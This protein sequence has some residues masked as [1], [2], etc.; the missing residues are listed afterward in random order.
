MS[1]LHRLY[2][3][4]CWGGNCCHVSIHRRENP[5]WHRWHISR[6]ELQKL[7]FGYLCFETL[8]KGL[9]LNSKYMLNPWTSTLAYTAHKASKHPKY[10][11]K[12]I[13]VT[14]WK[15][16]HIWFKMA[17]EWGI[18]FKLVNQ[19]IAIN[20]PYS[21]ICRGNQNFQGASRS[22]LLHE[23]QIFN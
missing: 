8:M 3:C 2:S 23:T 5:H 17:G 11:R 16:N 19:L 21:W 18:T 7:R 12:I 14:I 22:K 20:N 10:L 13:H 6:S 15:T 4:F 9:K 1:W